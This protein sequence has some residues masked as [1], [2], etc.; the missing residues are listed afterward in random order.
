LGPAHL[1]AFPCRQGKIQLQ[2][3]KSLFR[4]RKYA[5]DQRLGYIRESWPA[6]EFYGLAEEFGD[7][8]C[9]IYSHEYGALN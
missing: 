5:V 6:A 9:L 1:I 3:R 8:A 4:Q 2:A 7:A